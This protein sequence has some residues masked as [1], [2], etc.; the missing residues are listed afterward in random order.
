MRQRAGQAS[1]FGQEPWARQAVA[2][3]RRDWPDWAFLV[4]GYRWLAMRGKQVVISA[5]GPQELRQALPSIPPEPNVTGPNVT[6]PSSRSGMAVLGLVEGGVS[7]LGPVLPRLAELL[8]AGPGVGWAGVSGSPSSG[9]AWTTD[10]GSGGVC[11]GAGT[12]LSGTVAAVAP[13]PGALTAERSGTGTWAVAAADGARVGWW[14]YGWS[15]WSWGRRRDRSR[16][17]TRAGEGDRRAGRDRL[18]AGG[19][20]PRHRRVRSKPAAAVVAAAVAA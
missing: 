11:G 13:L 7:E 3:L 15:W 17:E 4:V 2:G 14:P 12:G 8:V 18:P 19:A 9:S 20:R 10:T 1:A 5:A 6:G 16:L